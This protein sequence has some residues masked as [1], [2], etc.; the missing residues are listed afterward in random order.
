[1]KTLTVNFH[2]LSSTAMCDV[3]REN[4]KT[5]IAELYCVFVRVVALNILIYLLTTLPH[6]YKLLII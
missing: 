5:P 4:I 2:C 1:M 6:T 3:R